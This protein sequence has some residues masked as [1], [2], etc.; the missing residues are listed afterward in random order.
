[1]PSL[2]AYGGRALKLSFGAADRLAPK[3]LRP[4]LDADRLIRAAG[5]RPSPAAEDGLRQLLAALTAE[6][7]LSLGGR[8]MIRWDMIRL[9]RN[10][11]L[12]EA[13]HAAEPALGQAEVAAPVFILG[14]PRSGTTFL[15]TLLAADPDNLVPRNWQTID[16]RPRPR[17][18]DPAKDRAARKVD[19]QLRIFAGMAPGFAEAHPITADSP[20][21][22]SEITAHVF[23]SFR[24]DTT[25][26]VPSYLAWLDRY[27]DLEGFRFHKRFLQVLQQGVGGRWL[28]KCPD[29][30]FS[31]EAILRVYPDARFVIVH[32]DPVDVFASVAHLTEVLRRPFLNNVDPA[33]IGAQVSQRW[34]DGAERLI[35]FDQRS[36]IAP[37][38][39]LHIHY[40]DLTA[41]PLAA[42]ARIYAQFGLRLTRAAAAAIGRQLA[43]RPNGGYA[44]HAPYSAQRFAIDPAVLQLRFAGYV[45]RYCRAGI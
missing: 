22:C 40:D 26:R 25:F 42:V 16:P 39:K 37:E 32:R 41:A 45:S 7:E 28:L 21:E 30:T 33:E 12:I 13:A 2:A 43:A 29:H 44:R 10:A 3:A 24:F 19:R 5:V 14:L 23:Q 18:F 8:M 17:G 31:L 15:H 34:I 9:L 4:A 1:M 27:G 11:A 35:A 6:S 20:Q 36:D 38:R